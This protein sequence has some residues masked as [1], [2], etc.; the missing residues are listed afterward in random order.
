MV[1]TI[2]RSRVVA[3]LLLKVA[4]EGRHFSVVVL[5]GRTDTAGADV[6]TVYADAGIPTTVVMDYVVG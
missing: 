5:E 4:S 3:S 1:L 2:V 6:A